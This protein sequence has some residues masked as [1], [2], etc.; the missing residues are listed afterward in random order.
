MLGRTWDNPEVEK[1]TKCETGHRPFDLEREERNMS[2]R[3][4]NYGNGRSQ[5]ETTKVYGHI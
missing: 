5:I 3:K 4:M 1:Q 2:N